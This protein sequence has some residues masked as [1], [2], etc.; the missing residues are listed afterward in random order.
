MDK[1]LRLGDDR[2]VNSPMPGAPGSYE[3][4]CPM[5]EAT[6]YERLPDGMYSC[7]VCN[8]SWGV[9]GPSTPS[10]DQ[11]EFARRVEGIVRH[12]SSD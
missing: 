3:I 4:E 10:P 8:T 12:H 2:W 6:E 1:S 5:C 7:Y 9:A 11:S